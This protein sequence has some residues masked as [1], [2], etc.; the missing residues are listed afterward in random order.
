MIRAIAVACVALP[1]LSYI[2]ST[3]DDDLDL[4]VMEIEITPSEVLGRVIVDT[5]TSTADTVFTDGLVVKYPNLPSPPPVEL[6]LSA[7]PHLYISCH[8][9]FPDIQPRGQVQR[10]L[11]LPL[12]S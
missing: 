10:R 2:E 8:S 7:P 6:L 11:R 5:S 3:F 4:E 12:A 9:G 1:L